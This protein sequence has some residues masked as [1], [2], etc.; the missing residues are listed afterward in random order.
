MVV[1]ELEVELYPGKEFPTAK[2]V[3]VEDVCHPP[4]RVVI[5]R[6]TVIMFPS[7]PPVTET[8]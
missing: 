8:V 2:V 3:V 6:E 4:P 5:D 1:V 7:Y